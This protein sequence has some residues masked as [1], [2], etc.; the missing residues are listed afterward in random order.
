MSERVLC[1]EVRAVLSV[2]VCFVWKCVCVKRV[3]ACVPPATTRVLLP[4]RIARRS[5][6][7]TRDRTKFNVISGRVPYYGT[8]ESSVLIALPHFNLLY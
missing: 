1:V 3:R 5:A 2:C 6:E 7:L 8:F 4:C